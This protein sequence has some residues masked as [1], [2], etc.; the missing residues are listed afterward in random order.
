MPLVKRIKEQTENEY[1]K[2]RWAGEEIAWVLIIFYFF[3]VFRVNLI[4][5][6]SE[7]AD[8]I[9]DMA[10][11]AFISALFGNIQKQINLCWANTEKNENSRITLQNL[12]WIGLCW[13]IPGII[14]ALSHL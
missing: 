7:L 3:S 9:F 11:L 5:I 4:V 8:F 13:A 6:K 2:R 10:Y 12:L 14:I 1:V